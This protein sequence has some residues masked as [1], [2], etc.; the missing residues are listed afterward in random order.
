MKNIVTI[1][2]NITNPDRVEFFRDAE[3]ATRLPSSFSAMRF[4]AALCERR[5]TIEV[6]TLR[7]SQRVSLAMFYAIRDQEIATCRRRLWQEC[8][9]RG[10]HQ[11]TLALSYTIT[12]KGTA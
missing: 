2:I 10:Y 5:A 7:H 6:D 3:S 12:L 4:L 11:T 9:A 1:D 8:I